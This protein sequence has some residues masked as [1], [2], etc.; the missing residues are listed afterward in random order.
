MGSVLSTKGLSF[1]QVCDN[2]EALWLSCRVLAYGAEG[3]RIEICTGPKISCY[4]CCALGQG[5]LLSFAPLHPG[6]LNGYW[7]RLGK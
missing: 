7:S 4:V 5:T 3:P 1:F 6:E 2:R